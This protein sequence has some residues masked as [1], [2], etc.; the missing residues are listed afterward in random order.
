MHVM[1]LGS[2]VIGTTVAYYLARSG[3]EVTV[4]GRKVPYARELWLPLFWI[5]R[6]GEE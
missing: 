2:G 6:K 5:F 1:V 4:D 3:H